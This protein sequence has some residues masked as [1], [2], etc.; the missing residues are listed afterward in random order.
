MRIKTIFNKVSEWLQKIK[1]W[2]DDMIDGIQSLGKNKDEEH[3]EDETDHDEDDVD[4]DDFD[5]DEY[6]EQHAEKL[7][8]IPV[9]E[10]DDLDDS[11]D[12]QAAI[13]DKVY[14]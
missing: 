14:N 5:V 10:V 8:Q 3:K 9:N 13:E 2:C 7:N 1:S 4:T 11:S 12:Q 6:I